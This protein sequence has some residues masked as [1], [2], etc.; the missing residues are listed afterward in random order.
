L[1]LVRLEC[2]LALVLGKLNILVNLFAEVS[3]GLSLSVKEE[4][5]EL[6]EVELDGGGGSSLLFL[7]L[8]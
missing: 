6:T 3:E 2:T 1:L 5:V 4:V 8:L 7:V